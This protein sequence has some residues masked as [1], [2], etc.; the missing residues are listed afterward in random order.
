MFNM[1]YSYMGVGVGLYL[2]DARCTLT[3][4]RCLKITIPYAHGGL[5]LRLISVTFT[6]CVP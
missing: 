1:L 6:I 5:S 4:H 2:L 3:L